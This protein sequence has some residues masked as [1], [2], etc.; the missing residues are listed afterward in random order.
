V[1]FDGSSSF[2]NE[3]A[4]RFTAV[5]SSRLDSPTASSGAFYALLTNGTQKPFVFTEHTPVTLVDN[6]EDVVSGKSKVLTVGA[7]TAFG[8]APGQWRCAVKATLNK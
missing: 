6:A 5:S 2:S 1:V 8:L 7:T 3:M 4:G